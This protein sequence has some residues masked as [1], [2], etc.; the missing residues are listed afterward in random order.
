MPVIT[1]PSH[2]T[3]TTASL[4]T[5]L[6][7]ILTSPLHLSVIAVLGCLAIG[8]YFIFLREY[9]C[10]FYN[11]PG[12]PKTHWFWG[13]MLEVFQHGPEL[14]QHLVGETYGHTYRQYVVGGGI[15]ASTVDLKAVNY[16]FLHPDLF[17]K[18]EGAAR[19]LTDALGRGLVTVEGHEH[20]RQ[21]RVVN[22]AFG[23]V[24]VQGMAPMIFEKAIELRHRLQAMVEH[25]NDPL[26]DGHVD[27]VPGSR[28]ID[29]L[30]PL[31]AATLDIIALVG[32]G[33]DLHV[34]DDA[35]NELREAYTSAIAAAFD[36][37]ALALAQIEVPALTVIVSGQHAYPF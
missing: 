27:K 15:H 32:F 20:R 3:V 26:P 13:N 23:W 12:P 14:L 29:V 6:M 8:V 5:N 30:K 7:M 4:Q 25:D 17:I 1:I 19:I 31:S 9:F 18:P 16:M 28:K 11:L 24:Q 35:P 36:I 33:Y 34:L 21:R 2:F 10:A 22:P 37:N